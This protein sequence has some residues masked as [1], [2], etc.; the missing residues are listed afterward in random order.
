MMAT[1]TATAK[2]RQIAM[3]KI[4]NSSTCGAKLE[5]CSG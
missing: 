3:M 2:N 5:A 4:I 1:V